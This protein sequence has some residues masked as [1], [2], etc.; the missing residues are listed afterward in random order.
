M[1]LNVCVNVWHKHH[2]QL[3]CGRCSWYL[4]SRY[5]VWLPC[6]STQ[7][8]SLCHRSAQSHIL[9]DLLKPPGKSSL[10]IVV[11]SVPL[12]YW[13]ALNTP[14]FS[15]VS[16][17]IMDKGQRIAQA[18]SLGLRDLSTINRQCCS[19]AARQRADNVAVCRHIRT[20]LYCLWWVGTCTESAGKSLKRTRWHTARVYSVR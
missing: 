20:H 9:L 8:S 14:M 16:S 1:K 7:I 13:S 6:R 2:S 4:Y 10:I 15:N 11:T 12:C 18:S 3:R 5:S 19:G 17:V